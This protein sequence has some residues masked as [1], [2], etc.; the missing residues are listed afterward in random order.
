MFGYKARVGLKSINTPVNEICN[1]SS[2]EDIEEIM[3]HP[4]NRGDYEIG[5]E[6]L[7]TAPEQNKKSIGEIILC[8]AFIVLY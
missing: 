4:E 5:R 6:S 3:P 2:E 1:L 7:I 8:I